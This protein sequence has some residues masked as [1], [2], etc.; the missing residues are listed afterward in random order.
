MRVNSRLF[1]LRNN[2]VHLQGKNIGGIIMA[3]ITL[4]INERSK[5]GIALRNLLEVLKTQPGIEIIEN[6]DSYKRF[7]NETLKAIDDAKTGKTETISLTQF[8]KQ[9]Y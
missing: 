3:T 1:C 6:N 2:F 7:N 8:R 4:K 5:V 9:L